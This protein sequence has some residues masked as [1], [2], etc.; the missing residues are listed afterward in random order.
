[1]FE[2]FRSTGERM[3]VVH[4]V[5]LL[6]DSNVVTTTLYVIIETDGELQFPLP[7]GSTI[8]RN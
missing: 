8:D 5:A 3:N 1:M 2:R 7:L 4:S 6:S